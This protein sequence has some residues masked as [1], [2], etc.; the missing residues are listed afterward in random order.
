MRMDFQGQRYRQDRVANV[1]WNARKSF[2]KICRTKN[3]MND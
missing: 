3:R 2:Q 1:K